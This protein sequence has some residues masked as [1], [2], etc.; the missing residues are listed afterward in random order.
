MWHKCVFVMIVAALPLTASAN[1]DPT[2]TSI[3]DA[4]HAALDSGDREGA[5]EFLAP[6]VII[7]E[8]GGAEMSRDEYASHHLEADMRF[9][10][11]LRREV[12]DRQSGISGD[13][14]WVL[15]KT[16]T[17]GTYRER[18]IDSRGTETMVLRRADGAWR[19]AHVH[20]S[21]ARP[22]SARS[23]PSAREV[24]AAY[25]DAM[26][27]GNL[28]D[29]EALFAA[30]SVIYES[31]KVEGAWEAYRARHIG[32]ELE[33]SKSFTITRGEPEE[34]ASRDGELAWVAWPIEYRIVLNDGR[35]VESRGTVSFALAREGG[36]LRIRHLH[37]S[38][39]KKR[40]APE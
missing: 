33:E 38:Y 18:E 14:A 22:S 26:E 23:G 2:P 13:S 37:W 34:Q 31:G 12:V 4:F 32:P 11:A 15:S 36:S 40:P 7:F 24:A 27:S 29:A 28:D 17:T 39:R 21:S 1:Q 9:S 20:W 5:L 8:S 16:R 35:E 10:A 19:I 6:E 25:F 30:E 3:V